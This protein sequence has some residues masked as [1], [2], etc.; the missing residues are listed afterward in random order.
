M[1]QDQPPE[2]LQAIADEILAIIRGNEVDL[3]KKIDTEALVGAKIR[4]D[5]FIDLCNVAKSLSDY[6]MDAEEGLN[7]I[8]A[9][10]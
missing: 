9:I 10:N 4:E 8:V 3:K 7:D 6:A 1:V 2:L 5:T